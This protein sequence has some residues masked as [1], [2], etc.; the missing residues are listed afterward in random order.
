[1]TQTSM[2]SA[3]D[4]WSSNKYFGV[5]ICVR[6]PRPIGH[7]AMHGYFWLI[8]MHSIQGSCIFAFLFRRKPLP[9]SNMGTIPI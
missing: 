8:N 2:A 7:A 1:M 9:E 5:V 4:G 3:L 6:M